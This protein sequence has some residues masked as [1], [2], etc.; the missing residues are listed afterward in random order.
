MPEIK[1]AA[2]FIEPMLLVRNGDT[3]AF[4]CAECGESVVIATPLH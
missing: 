3:G 2:R 1:N 4:V